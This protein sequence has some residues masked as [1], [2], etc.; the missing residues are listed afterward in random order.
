MKVSKELMDWVNSNISSYGYHLS[1]PAFWGDGKL[2]IQTSGCGCCSDE[3]E[4]SP[5]DLDNLIED[6]RDMLDLLLEIK[7]G[8]VDDNT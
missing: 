4:A 8:A 1:I 3:S 2:V 6:Y 5:E 7:E